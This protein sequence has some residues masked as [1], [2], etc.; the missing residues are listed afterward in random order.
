MDRGEFSTAEREALQY[1]RFHH[2]HPRVQRKLEA[3]YLRSQGISTTEVCRL[4]AI[5]PSTYARR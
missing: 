1:W 4:C 5:A 2:P 3:L